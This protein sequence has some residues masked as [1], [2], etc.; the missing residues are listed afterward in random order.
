MLTIMG[1][2]ILSVGMYASSPISSSISR[3]LYFFL[4]D[5]DGISDSIL[6]LLNHLQQH[7]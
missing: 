6:L 4:S 2:D 1:T 3:F 7:L 5:R